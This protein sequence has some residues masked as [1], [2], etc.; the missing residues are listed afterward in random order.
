MTEERFEEIM[1][2]YKIAIKHA[3][4]C[5]VRYLYYYID[6]NININNRNIVEIKKNNE[7]EA[8]KSSIERL[9]AKNEILQNIKDYIL[10]YVDVEN[11]NINKKEVK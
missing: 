3:R 6:E 10:L 4:D 2:I 7:Q 5:I 8:I 11:K 9:E 1:R